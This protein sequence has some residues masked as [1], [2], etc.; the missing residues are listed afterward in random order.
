MNL[1]PTPEPIR[2]MDTDLQDTVSVILRGSYFIS[3]IVTVPKLQR[4]SI[5]G[6]PQELG[7]HTYM[8]GIPHGGPLVDNCGGFP[9]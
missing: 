2:G 7:I 6:L 1:T 5:H 4:R 3:N 8:A 9:H